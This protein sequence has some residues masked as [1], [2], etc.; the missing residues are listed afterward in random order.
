MRHIDFR[1]CTGACGADQLSRTS[2]ANR[3]PKSYRG[4]VTLVVGEYPDAVRVAEAVTVSYTV[5]TTASDVDPSPQTGIFPAG[6]LSLTVLVPFSTTLW[7]QAVSGKF[8]H[9]ITLRIQTTR[10]PSAPG[11]TVGVMIFKACR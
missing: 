3:D 9:S 6:L 5:D 11:R 7:R 1:D 2:P 8:R 10:F 4:I